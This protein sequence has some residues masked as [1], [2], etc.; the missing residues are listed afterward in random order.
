MLLNDQWVIEEITEEI[1]KFLGLNEN[2]NT[3]C[4][5]LWGKAK[6]ILRDLFIAMSDY[7]K[8]SEIFQMNNLIMHHKLLK[9]ARFEWQN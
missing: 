1:L 7:I 4:Q 9:K 8:K 5:C 6:A 3:T 2:E